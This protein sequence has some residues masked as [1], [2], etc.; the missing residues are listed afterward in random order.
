VFVSPTGWAAPSRGGRVADRDRS[1][2]PGLDGS[3]SPEERL[4]VRVRE[5]NREIYDRSRTELGREGMGTT[6]TAAYLDDGSV[7]IAHVGDSRAYLFRDASSSGS[8]GTTR[9]STSWSGAGS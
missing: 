3:G 1:F 2:E 9:S 7:A 4:A 6:L 8:P 5:A